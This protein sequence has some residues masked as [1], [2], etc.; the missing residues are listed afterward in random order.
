MRLTL[1]NLAH[2][3]VDKGF[4]HPEHLVN[5]SYKVSQRQ[6]RN[7][8]FQVF[9]GD[10]PSGL[11]VKQLLSLDPQN[12]YLMQKDATAHCIIHQTD[13]LPQMRGFVPKYYG[14]EPGNHVFVTEFF[15]SATSVHELITQ[16]KSLDNEELNQ[17]AFILASLHKDL[18][19]Q[20]EQTPALEFFN[21]QAPWMML[22][23]DQDH[24]LI[25]SSGQSMG[26]VSQLIRQQPEFTQLLEELRYEW[27]GDYLVHGD[28]KLVNFIRV[29]DNG[30]ES[31]KLIDWEISDLGD[32]LWDVAGLLQSLITLWVFSQ[33]PNP[34]LQNQPQAGMEFLTWE[35]V[36]SS[37]QGFWQAYLKGRSLYNPDNT[38]NTAESRHKLIRFTAARMMQ[39]A[40][41]ANMHTAD[42][43]P[44]SNKILQIVTQIINTPDA[45]ASQ[46]LGE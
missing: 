8:I 11:F 27:S 18:S 7:S 5:G 38:L 35:K 23:G 36:L 4:L 44:H 10:Q 19:D 22:F 43:Q 39:T 20:V 32:P 16:R 21:R 26:A 15:S 1:H 9:L 3:L 41:E 28:I 29:A 42:I 40:C 33:N 25:K 31:L 2:F 13:L 6:S 34:M 30:T 12:A 46:V 45:W 24:P 17:M 14:Y 37:S